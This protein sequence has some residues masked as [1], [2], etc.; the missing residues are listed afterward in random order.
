MAGGW[1][2]DGAVHKQ[3][4]ATVDEWQKLGHSTTEQQQLWAQQLQMLWQDVEQD[5]ILAAV[6]QVDGSVMFYFNGVET[7]ILQDTAFGTAFF[8]IWLHPDTSA[9][10]LRRQ[11]IAAQ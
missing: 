8:D 5:D 3:I 9:P 4:D 10:K 2:E 1:S 11:L 6:L 7:G